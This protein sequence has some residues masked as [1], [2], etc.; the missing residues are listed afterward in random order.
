[1][2]VFGSAANA[3][4]DSDVDGG[5]G[6]AS[7]TEDVAPPFTFDASSL[8]AV[9][10][11][12][13]ANGDDTSVTAGGFKFNLPPSQV[14]TVAATEGGDT[15]PLFGSTLKS[16][17]GLWSG[18]KTQTKHQG[19]TDGGSG[20]QDAHIAMHSSVATRAARDLHLPAVLPADSVAGSEAL[21]GDALLHEDGVQRLHSRLTSTGNGEDMCVLQNA[22]SKERCGGHTC[23]RPKTCG[24]KG[25]QGDRDPRLCILPR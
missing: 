4:A 13:T 7:S 1:M 12:P 11:T 10:S 22:H 20:K 16:S 14:L 25:S 8:P 21:S 9:T 6:K 5:R 23:P 24:R 17:Q 19:A 3:D 2:F 18:V 15:T